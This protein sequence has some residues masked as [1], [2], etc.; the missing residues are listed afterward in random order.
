MADQLV[1]HF[2]RP[3]LLPLHHQLDLECRTGPEG[4]VGQVPNTAAIH[5]K[6]DGARRQW[7]AGR[8]DPDH[9]LTS[10]ADVAALRSD[11]CPPR[12]SAR[13][14]SR[15]VNCPPWS[16]CA[17]TFPGSWTTRMPGCACARS[18]AGNLCR[19]CPQ[20]SH[21]HAGPD[22]RCGDGPR[23]PCRCGADPGLAAWVMCAIRP[24]F[25]CG[26]Y[27]RATCHEPL[28]GPRSYPTGSSTTTGISRSVFFA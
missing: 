22:H 7:R 20:R 9:A 28:S 27:A 18:P 21:E 17:G 23:H 14:I 26:R 24:G 4:L 5:E 10:A 8:R 1:R 11:A 19:P 2:Q 12:P 13:P 3:C 6:T 15:A 16:S 25:T